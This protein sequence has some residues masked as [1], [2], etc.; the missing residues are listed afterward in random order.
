LKYS[1]K[2]LINKIP[3]SNDQRKPNTKIRTLLIAVGE[4]LKASPT[5]NS[6]RLSARKNPISSISFFLPNS[7][8]QI[9]NNPTNKKIKVKIVNCIFSI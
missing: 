5:I 8:N 2:D 3:K 7:E 6:I 4:K 9:R 1:N